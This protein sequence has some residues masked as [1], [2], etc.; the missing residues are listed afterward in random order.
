MRSIFILL[1]FTVNSIWAQSSL[2]EVEKRIKLLSEKQGYEHADI[3]FCLVDTKSGKVLYC[4]QAD[5]L[6]APASTLKTYTTATA[7][8]LLGSDYRYKTKF[9]FEGVQIAQ[10]A[11]GTLWVYTSGDPSLGSDRYAETKAELIKNELVSSFKKKG[12]THWRGNIRLMP[13]NYTDTPINKNWLD[14]DV[15]NYYGA[16]IYPLNWRENKFEITLEPTKNSFRV[17]RN[18][19]NYNNERDFCVSVTHKDAATTEEVFAFIENKKWC[20]YHLKGVLSNKEKSF[21]LLLASLRPDVDFI[22]ELE[23]YFKKNLNYVY[24]DTSIA[25]STKTEIYTHSSPPLGKLAYWCNQ[26]SLNLYAES[27]CKTMALHRFKKGNWQLGTSLM[28]NYAQK[29]GIKNKGMQLDDGSGLSENN[30]IT[31]KILSSLL[32]SYTKESFFPVFYE[33]LPSI[34]GLIM[35]SGYIGGTRSYAGYIKLKDGTDAS[36]AFIVHG[37]SVTPKEVKIQMFQILDLLKAN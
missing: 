34:N 31:T 21:N 33:S 12:I 24:T 35:K 7:L 37:Y 26:K 16:G 27:F 32:A 23:S 22:T 2:D 13:C 1:F 18:T 11:F 36:F 20:K 5:K 29:L 15:G 6:L 19:G 3:S 25:N 28:A 4:H 10:E 9:V 14:E 30:R 8:K 17:I